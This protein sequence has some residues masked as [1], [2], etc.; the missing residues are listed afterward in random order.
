M[1][2]PGT[3]IKKG[4]VLN[5]NGRPKKEYSLTQGMREY[6]SELDGDS[7]KELRRVFLEKTHEMAL[8]G[9]P[10]AMKLIW[11]YLDGMPKQTIEANINLA[12][13]MAEVYKSY[14]QSDNDQQ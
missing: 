6:L 5:P 4:Q 3:Y 10:T 13:Q 14:H 2:N 9:D 7:K 8:K 1:S 12:E 11:N